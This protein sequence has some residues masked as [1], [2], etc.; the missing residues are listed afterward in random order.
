AGAI[1]AS[2][3]AELAKAGPEEE[4]A[5][6]LE[7]AVNILKALTENFCYF[8]PENDRLL[9]HGSVRYPVDGDLKKNGVHISLIYGDYFYTEAILKLMGEKYLPW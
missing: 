9:G 3:M 7:A 6:Y 4:G 1:A 8:E 5:K 2:G